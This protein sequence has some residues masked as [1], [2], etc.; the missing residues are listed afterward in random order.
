MHT[1]PTKSPGREPSQTDAADGKAGSP[2]LGGHAEELTSPADATLV[3]QARAREHDRDSDSDDT[4]RLPNITKMPEGY[5]VVEQRVGRAV[6]QWV[7]L[8][9][10][11][12]GRRWF[13]V[14]TIDAATCPRCGLLVY[15]DVP[16][17]GK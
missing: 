4:S 14:E 9:R 6:A 17:R 12:C 16:A 3:G 15:V 5:E 2:A 8:V 13:E 1:R 7:L 11:Q 10:C